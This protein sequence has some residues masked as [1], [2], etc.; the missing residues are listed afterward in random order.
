MSLEAKGPFNC[1]YDVAEGGRVSGIL[2]SMQKSRPLP[3]GQIELPRAP[4]GNV[5]SNNSG[6]LFTKRLDSD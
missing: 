5:G 1:G 2:Q 6:N 3:R 4:I